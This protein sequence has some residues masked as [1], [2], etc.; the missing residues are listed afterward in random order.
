MGEKF[1]KNSQLP[2]YI[3]NLSIYKQ[4]IKTELYKHEKNYI[5][6]HIICNC[7]NDKTQKNDARDNRTDNIIEIPKHIHQYAHKKLD[8][9]EKKEAENLYNKYKETL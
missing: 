3:G 5:A 2:F 1:N 7:P 8:K 6:H 9:N 4:I